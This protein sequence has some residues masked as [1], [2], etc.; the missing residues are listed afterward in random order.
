MTGVSKR[1]SLLGT[2]A[3]HS[4]SDPAAPRTAGQ[5]GQQLGLKQSFHLGDLASLILLD[6]LCEVDGVWVLA[7]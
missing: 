6:L 3:P 1:R 2:R 5:P 4:V 7:V